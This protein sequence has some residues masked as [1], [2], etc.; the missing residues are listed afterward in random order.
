MQQHLTDEVSHQLEAAR[1]HARSAVTVPPTARLSGVKKVVLR[2]ARM[3][4]APQVAATE[5][6]A[7]AVVN[8]SSEMRAYEDS[9]TTKA[10]ALE[11][12]LQDTVAALE[13]RLLEVSQQND[14][15]TAT[16]A[17]TRREVETVRLSAQSSAERLQADLR[18]QG[19][20]TSRLVREVRG[21]LDSG[22]DVAQVPALTEAQE[23]LEAQFY[24]DFEAVFRGSRAEIRA[25]QEQHVRR[26]QPTVSEGAPLL[27]VGCGRGE[28][29]EVLRDAGLPAYGVD[30]NS[31]FVTQCSERGLDARLGDA[32]EHL[33]QL[34]AASLGA[35]SAIH[36]VEHLPLPV[37]VRLI[38]A[39]L[40]ALRPGGVLLL[41][42]PNPT[43]V[44]VGAAAFYMDPTHLRPVHPQFLEFLVQSRGFVDA[45]IH[46][47]HPQDADQRPYV[48]EDPR[49]AELLGR[50]AWALT[51]PQDYAVV[52]RRAVPPA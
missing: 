37:V 31:R 16:L 33:E 7:N 40:H 8:V 43:N 25:L 46:Y 32:L 18:R 21:A 51:G 44:V 5:S 20:L 24:D 1:A 34:P 36:L 38:D 35:V 50:T 10:V 28:W 42:T 23:A 48:A 41:E 49:L 12:G 30:T 15:L 11:M 3:L 2:G 14:E 47:L 45:E 27:D 29:L 19:G 13:R 4:T 22:G 6:L 52:A 17:A 9:A 26:V 39:A